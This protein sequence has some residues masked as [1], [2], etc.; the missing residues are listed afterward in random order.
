MDLEQLELISKFR[1]LPEAEVLLKKEINNYFQNYEHEE[2]IQFLKIAFDYLRE[3]KGFLPIEYRFLC[4]LSEFYSKNISIN[5]PHIGQPQTIDFGDFVKVFLVQERRK[6]LFSSLQVFA[7]Q[8]KNKLKVN[9]LEV[10]IGGSFTEV[11]NPHPNDLDV[12]ILVG[13]NSDSV[14][15]EN[16]L[17]ASQQ[18]PPGID[19]K[20]LPKN[21]S[22]KTY[23]AYSN[24]TH[25]GNKAENKSKDPL[26]NN[27]FERRKIFKLIL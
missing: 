3:K 9:E 22:I 12:V 6:E 19:L 23:K 27:R 16:Y 18:V 20:I 11:E 24:I 14:I 26:I 4:W 15:H 1:V 17:Y 5:K 10:L 2:D 21:Y 25:L 8:I 7:E 13:E